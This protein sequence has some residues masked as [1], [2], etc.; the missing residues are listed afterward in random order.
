MR[1]AR[2]FMLKG[3]ARRKG[4][5]KVNRV[6]SGIWARYQRGVWQDD[7]DNVTA[8]GRGNRLSHRQN[9]K[10]RELRNTERAVTKQSIMKTAFQNIM[11]K[12]TGKGPKPAAR[13]GLA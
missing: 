1:K 4:Y 7:Y 11:A 10:L 9:R 5:P 2:R 8:I 13:S 12:V 6:F 3:W